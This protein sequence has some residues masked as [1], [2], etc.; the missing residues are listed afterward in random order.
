MVANRRWTVRKHTGTGIGIPL[1]PAEIR[2][3]YELARDGRGVTEIA[4]TL[5]RSSKSVRNH[6]K[7]AGIQFQTA[8]WT[9]GEDAKL[10]HLLAQRCHSYQIACVMGRSEYGI[11]SR[12]R[13]LGL[14]QP[15]GMTYTEWTT[16]IR[17]VE[18]PV[19]IR[20]EAVPPEPDVFEPPRDCWDED[21]AI[22]G[23]HG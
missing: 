15:D 7:A 4:R 11:Q 19:R 20:C 10:R 6:A 13:R 23:I 2:R 3:I 18:K 12:M 1:Q 8:V 5:G 21:R 9:P 16:G 17:R 14:P 22:G